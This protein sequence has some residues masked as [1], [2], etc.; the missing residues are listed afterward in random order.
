MYVTRIAGTS[1][2][3]LRII[4]MVTLAACLAPAGFTGAQEHGREREGNERGREH[5]V[6]ILEGLE[7]GMVAL[8]KLGRG[9]ELEM[10]QR[11]ANDVRRELEQHG[12]KREDNA[13]RRAALEQLEV[14]RIARHALLE[15][16]RPDAADLLQMAIRAREVGLEGRRDEEA[17]AIRKRAPKREQLVKLLGAATEL[18]QKF[19][20]PDKAEAVAKFARQL[21]SRERRGDERPQERSR[22]GRGEREV[23]LHELEIM[24]MAMPALLEAGRK[25]TAELLE[26]AIRLREIGLE[27]GA[28]EEA[29]AIR[30]KAPNLGQQVEILSYASRLWREFGNH[31]KAEAVGGLAE[32]MLGRFRRAQERRGE[33]RQAEEGRRRREQEPSQRAESG[34]RHRIDALQ[35]HL[36]ELRHALDDMRAELDAIR[37]E[38]D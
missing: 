37:R 25:D 3:H 14:L 8:D 24:R 15:A 23:A 17:R 13:E 28:D 38:H 31:D 22:E 29:L 27:G 10:L 6:N 20:K 21:R 26:L 33:Q 35:H 4:A 2:T 9:A 1:Q 5:L 16:E 18:W 12:R 19:G 11:V 32:E 36:E 34:S 30:R 7:H